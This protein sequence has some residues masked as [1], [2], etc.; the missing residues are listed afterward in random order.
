MNVNI[1][2]STPGRH[3]GKTDVIL[4][5]FFASATISNRYYL[6]EMFGL[7]WAFFSFR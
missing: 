3:M 2:L 4:H 1:S 7:G 5:S 6:D